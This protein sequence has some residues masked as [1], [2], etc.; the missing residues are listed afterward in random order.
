MTFGRNLPDKGVR[1]AKLLVKVTVDEAGEYDL[2]AKL[3]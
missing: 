1:I 3:T 2:W